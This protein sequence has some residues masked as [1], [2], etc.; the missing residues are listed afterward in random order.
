MEQPHIEDCGS[1]IE[2]S[3]SA[4]GF[5]QANVVDVLAGASKRFGTKPMLVICGD[6]GGVVEMTRA[7]DV[8]VELS[9]K[10]PFSCIA[11]ALNE[12]MSTSADRVT[13]LVAETRGSVVRYFESVVQAKTWR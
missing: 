2:V 10:L 12:R 8:G 3:L 5:G 13:E 9:A 11:I 4:R 7:Y 1:H 6:P